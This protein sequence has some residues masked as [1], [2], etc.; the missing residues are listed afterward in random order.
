MICCILAL[1]VAGPLGILLAPVWGP[2]RPATEAGAVCC[3]PR[4]GLWRGVTILLVFVVFCALFATA[5]HFMDPPAFRQ[6]CTFHVF[7]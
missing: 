6:F 4:L 2:R 3:P 7:R 5:L 1:L